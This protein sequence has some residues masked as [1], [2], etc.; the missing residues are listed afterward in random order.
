[1]PLARPVD[2]FEA[3]AS[4]RPYSL[5]KHLKEDEPANPQSCHSVLQEVFRLPKSS[6][7]LRQIGTET[8]C[9][10]SFKSARSRIEVGTCH[11]DPPQLGGNWDLSKHT[12]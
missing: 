12:M 8:T 9:P 5:P 4:L 7:E 1:M 6:T 3:I 10:P 11:L 2:S